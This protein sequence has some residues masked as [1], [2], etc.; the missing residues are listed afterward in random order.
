MAKLWL[1]GLSYCQYNK[2]QWN[3]LR[4]FLKLLGPITGHLLFAFTYLLIY[5]FY[6]V[7]KF[8]LTTVS[9]KF[10]NLSLLIIF[11]T[12]RSSTQGMLSWKR[13]FCGCTV[14][15]RPGKSR[16]LNIEESLTTCLNY[17]LHICT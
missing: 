17:I 14:N 10:Y 7:N 4:T 1:L 12:Y 8:L 15:F 6:S 3:N 9:N 2:A 16:R 11:W 13:V 5:L